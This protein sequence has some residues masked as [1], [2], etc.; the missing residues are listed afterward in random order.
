MEL[1]EILHVGKVREEIYTVESQH[2]ATHVGS[3][4]ARVLATPWMIA[5]I[6]RTARDLLAEVLPEG[7]SSV[8]VHIDVRHLAPSPIG[9]HVRAWVEVTA[10]QGVKVDFTAGAWDDQELIGEGTHQRVIIEE[11]RFLQRVERKMAAQTGK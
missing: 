8:G 4:S 7:Y 3:G 2:S 9:S 6:E 11:E 10:I 1:S 5:F